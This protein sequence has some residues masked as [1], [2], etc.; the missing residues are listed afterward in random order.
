MSR[1]KK[2]PTID[3]QAAP[4]PATQQVMAKINLSGTAML[5]IRVAHEIQAL[6]AEHAVGLDYTYRSGNSPNVDYITT[7]NVPTVDVIKKNTKLYD[8]T[9]LTSSQ[10]YKWQAAI[11][12]GEGDAV[13][14][15]ADFAA[16]TGE[17]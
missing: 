11:R 17:E 5:P 10:V 7:Y 13:M 15:P 3:A 14:E 16:L 6:L 2:E 9:M 1:A 4:Q 12:A 8:A